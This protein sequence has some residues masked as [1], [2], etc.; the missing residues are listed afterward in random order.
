MAKVHEDLRNIAPLYR[1]FPAEFCMADWALCEHQF[2]ICKTLPT[3][4]ALVQL[5]AYQGPPHSQTSSAIPARHPQRPLTG[6]DQPV[7]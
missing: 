7:I 1:C 4:Y 6:P 2:E 3:L 5:A